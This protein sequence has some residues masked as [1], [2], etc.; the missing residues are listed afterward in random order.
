MEWYVSVFDPETKRSQVR[1]G[2]A[3]D[4]NTAIRSIVETGRAL[5][6]EYGGKHGNVVVN[7]RPG[8]T[9]PFGDI[10]LTDE[11]LADKV[12]A[13]IDYLQQRTAELERRAAEEAAVVPRPPTLAPGEA[14]YSTPSGDVSEQWSRISAW[15]STNGCTAP[16]EGAGREAIDDAEARSGVTWP[17]EL[18]ELFGNV[19]GVPS[20]RWFSFFP[21]H[22][23][24]DLG[25][26]VDEHETQLRVW[27]QF[28]DGPGRGE[29]RA[30]DPAGTWLPGFLPFAGL[31]GNF[32]IVDCRPGSLH[33]CVSEFDRD[34]AD[35]GPR[36]VSL[37][38]MLT[39]LAD[40]LADGGKFAGVWTPKIVAGQ[41]E[42]EH[43]PA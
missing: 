20:D 8:N 16:I 13:A 5:A 2:E 4:R 28:G 26:V 36:W 19:N 9:V 33:G 27:G 38:A 17:A 41:L 12:Q 7:E 25:Q 34:G 30:G 11:Q 31:D 23:L 29:S 22:H 6:R 39:D 3:P 1:N 40:V 14:L 43:H 15:L 42:W 32:L 21:A 37:S 10:S 24:F 18:R 35:A